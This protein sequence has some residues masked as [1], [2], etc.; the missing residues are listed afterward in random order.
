MSLWSELFVLL[1]TRGEEMLSKEEGKTMNTFFQNFHLN[2]NIERIHLSSFM[3]IN[4]VSSH[5]SL[6]IVELENLILDND[7]TVGTL[8]LRLK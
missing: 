6:L 3:V 5:C 1:N 7:G 2:S 8:K 4:V